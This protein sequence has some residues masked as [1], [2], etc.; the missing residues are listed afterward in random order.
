[1]AFVK[2]YKGIHADLEQPIHIPSTK[3]HEIGEIKKTL[4]SKCESDTKNWLMNLL[5]EFLVRLTLQAPYHHLDKYFKDTHDMRIALSTLE[6]RATQRNTV[7]PYVQQ[8]DTWIKEL[9]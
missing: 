5:K 2:E 3:R 7:I 1:M 6:A 8:L 9:E 4:E